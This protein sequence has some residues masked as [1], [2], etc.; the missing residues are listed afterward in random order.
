MPAT[1]N[2][3]LIQ[4]TEAQPKNVSRMPPATGPTPKPVPPTAAQVPMAAARSGAGKVSVRMDSVRA[5]MAAPP[6]PCTARDAISAAALGDSAQP[7]D[8]RAKMARPARNT[9]LRP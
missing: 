8:P 7:A 5:S 9:R 4:N 1:A 6:R 3:T 2:G